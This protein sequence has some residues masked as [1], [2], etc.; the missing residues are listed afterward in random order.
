[1]NVH[2]NSRAHSTD[3]HSVGVGIANTEYPTVSLAEANAVLFRAQF[4]LHCVSPGVVGLAVFPFVISASRHTVSEFVTERIV[5]TLRVLGTQIET[6]VGV[7]ITVAPLATGAFLGGVTEIQADAVDTSLAVGA[8]GI[9]AA[10][11]DAE[12]T[13]KVTVLAQ[14]AVR[15]IGAA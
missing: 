11:V 15:I 4:D 8:S 14:G 13:N 10:A 12:P 9:I 1:L 7:G 2:S 6:I 5:F 3:V